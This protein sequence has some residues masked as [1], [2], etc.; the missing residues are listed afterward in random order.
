MCIVRIEFVGTDTQ[1]SRYDVSIRC[2]I[3][4]GNLRFPLT[5]F[6][7]DRFTCHQDDISALVMT[8]HLEVT[9]GSALLPLGARGEVQ[10]GR[11]V[12]LATDIPR[13]DHGMSIRDGK[14]EQTARLD[15]RHIILLRDLPHKLIDLR[16]RLDHDPPQER[17]AEPL[18]PRIRAG[19]GPFL[20]HQIEEQRK[21][22]L[23]VRAALDAQVPLVRE[24]GGQRALD[25]LPPAD[26]AVVHPHERVVLERVAVVL[27]ERA[28]RGGPHVGEDQVR[29]RLGRQAFQVLAVPGR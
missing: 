18:G 24:R 6:E 27:R 17:L 5:S 16:N 20:L 1:L 10:T 28:L 2:M 7:C 21:G 9:L 25:V 29:A 19:I 14:V 26:A 13:A 4:F 3:C 15:V 11:L 22:P 23:A 8:L 12:R